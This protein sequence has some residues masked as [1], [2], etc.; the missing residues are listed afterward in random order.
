MKSNIKALFL[1]GLLIFVP[2]A[3]TLYV[4]VAGFE[5]LDGILR[6]FIIALIGRAGSELYIPGISLL[7]LIALIT[8]LGAFAK[9][10]L[11]EK[12]VNSFENLLLKVPVVKGIYSTVKHASSA[13]ISNQSSFMGVVLVEYP[14]KGVY[15]IGLTTAVGVKEIQDKTKQTMINVFIPTSPNPT[16]GILLMVPEDDVIKLDMSV[17][18][19]LKLVISGGF[20]NVKDVAKEPSQV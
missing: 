5:F 13:F 18:E 1:T 14:R 9:F 2:L 20:S 16:S 7:V 15:T 6:P 10:T 17:D 19:G 11:G 8:L 3:V 4:L 12:L